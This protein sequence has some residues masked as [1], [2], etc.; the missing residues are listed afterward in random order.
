ML[1]TLP[2]DQRVSSPIVTLESFAHSSSA[3]FH[4]SSML[5]RTQSRTTTTSIKR[6]RLLSDFHV[7]MGLLMSVVGA[8]MLSVPYTFVLI[9]RAQAVI[10]IVVVGILMGSTATALLFAHVQVA[11]EEELLLRPVGAEKRSTSFQSLAVNAGGAVFG[12]IASVVTAFGI[13]G[14]CVGCIRIVRDMTPHLVA[15]L[16]AFAN[17][18]DANSISPSD[19][20]LAEPILLWG[21]F[22]VVVFPLC[23]LKNLS[24]L[25]VTNYLGFVFSIY[26]VVMVTY[27]S[28]QS[29]QHGPPDGV[30]WS[31]ALALNAS[32][33]ADTSVVPHN[34]DDACVQG[35]CVNNTTNSTLSIRRLRNQVDTVQSSLGQGIESTSTSPPSGASFS[36]FAQSISIYNFAFM[37]HLN[38][39]PIFIQL[40]GSFDVP[41]TGARMRMTKGIAVV[42]LFCVALYLVFGVCGS[43]LY[44][45]SIKGN[46]LLNLENDPVMEIPLVAVYLAVIVT[47]PLLF[48]P[49]RNIVEEL[50]AKK[51]DMCSSTS[52]TSFSKRLF[53]TLGLLGAALLVAMRVPRIEVVFALVGATTCTMICFVFPVV[54]FARVYPW[55]QTAMGRVWVASL[56]LIVA[57]EVVMGGAV[58]S[59][60]LIMQ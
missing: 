21:L 45:E 10:G 3:H 1:S 60:L 39:L 58:V 30:A 4:L 56:W 25:T 16:Y 18:A 52:P 44:G 28:C 6:R 51:N 38:L 19:Q 12:Y 50:V 32:S 53:L 48:H 29:V 22:V 46:V 57:F 55:Q 35:A 34:G 42:T 47:F 43:R 40:R 54:I 15:L 37:M 27:R 23:L 14:G 13:F 5:A 2:S 41:M 17:S 26:L 11:S 20:R 8:G 31:N 24:A 7:L 36:R 33:T 59:S 49:M 9:P